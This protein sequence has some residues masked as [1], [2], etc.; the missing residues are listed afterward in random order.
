MKKLKFSTAAFAVA[1]SLMALSSCGQADK[2]KTPQK[3]AAAAAAKVGELPNFRYVDLDTLMTRYNLAKDFN[4][5]MLRMQNNLDNTA[6]QKEN[7]LRNY[8]AGV[9]KKYQNN[10]YLTEAEQ[11]AVQAEQQKIANMEEA[12]RRDLASLQQNLQN[13]ALRQQATLSDSI[14]SFIEAYNAKK[15][16]DAIL[17][18]G[19]GLYFNPA[20][21]ITEEV[22]EGL[23]ARYNKVNDK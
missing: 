4:E 21:D 18:K 14:N 7:S 1:L 13:V 2:G 16:Y 23:N 19:A 11:Q 12:A 3:S 6:R 8:A 20:L 17:F 15:G 22:V 5:E 10:T 9:Q